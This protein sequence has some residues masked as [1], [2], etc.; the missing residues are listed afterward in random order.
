MV[1]IPINFTSQ[2]EGALGAY[3]LS[4]EHGDFSQMYFPAIER[5]GDQ[6]I[7]CLNCSAL[8]FLAL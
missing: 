3:D 5:V 7:K 8:R 2:I 4:H 1:G 6:E